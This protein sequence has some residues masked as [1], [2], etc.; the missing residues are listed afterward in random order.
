MTGNIIGEGFSD[1]L[2]DEIKRRQKVH[3][4]G[5]SSKRSINQIQYLNNRNA[6]LKMASSVYVIGDQTNRDFRYEGENESGGNYF[7]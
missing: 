4:S 7:C 1:K 3:G 2:K 6:W 5:F